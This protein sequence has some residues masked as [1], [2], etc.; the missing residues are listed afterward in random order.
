MSW[1]S[2]ADAIM[3]DGLLFILSWP[4]SIIAADFLARK[5]VGHAISIEPAGAGS[6]SR[7]LCWQ[8]ARKSL[9]LWPPQ[10]ISA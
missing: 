6:L 3:N 5:D 7:M 10:C 9:Q 1:A 2:P 4:A 8:D